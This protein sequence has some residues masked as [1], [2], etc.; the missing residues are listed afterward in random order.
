V[1]QAEAE[2]P[3]HRE[4]DP[5]QLGTVRDRATQQTLRSRLE[6]VGCLSGHTRGNAFADRKQ[7]QLGKWIEVRWACSGALSCGNVVR[8]EGFEPPTF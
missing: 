7:H 1:R 5:S 8:S 2:V 6:R 3:A 4:H